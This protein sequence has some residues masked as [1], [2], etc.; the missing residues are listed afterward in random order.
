MN[1]CISVVFS[2]CAPMKL[3]IISLLLM[4]VFQAVLR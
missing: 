2:G 3:C 4:L 1:F